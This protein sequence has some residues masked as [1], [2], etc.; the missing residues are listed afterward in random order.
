MKINLCTKYIKLTL[1]YKDSPT[2]GLPRSQRW[3]DSDLEGGTG[4]FSQYWDWML[5]ATDWWQQA[6]KWHKE[7][8]RK[9]IPGIGNIF[10]SYISVLKYFWEKVPLK[11][12]PKYF[13][14]WFRVVFTSLV[15]QCPKFGFFSPFL[16]INNML[17]QNLPWSC[18]TTSW[19]LDRFSASPCSFHRGPVAWWSG[20]LS[21]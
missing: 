18:R 3:M 1:H 7:R 14:N 4:C 8:L 15:L 12:P 21:W 19:C 9:V 13:S 16:K 17:M 20:G 11:S 5:P 6:L 10:Y 2:G